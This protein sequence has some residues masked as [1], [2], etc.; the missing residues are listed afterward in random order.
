MK[1]LG[2]NCCVKSF[3]TKRAKVIKFLMKQRFSNTPGWEVENCLLQQTAPVIALT[4]MCVSHLIIITDIELL[5]SEPS[6]TNLNIFGIKIGWYSLKKMHLK[7]SPAKCLPSG[8]QVLTHWGR[9]KMAAISKWIFLNENARNPIKISLKFVPRG[10]INNIPSLVQIM[11][12]CR[13]G[14]KPLSEPMM[15]KFTDAYMRHSASMS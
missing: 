6:G 9:D 3:V 11:A 8:F 4:H 5:S 15:V 12:W 10:L 1:A 7:M 13:S 14:D 2:D